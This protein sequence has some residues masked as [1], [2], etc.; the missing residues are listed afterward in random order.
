M[1]GV[2]LADMVAAH[3]EPWH[4]QA[5]CVGQPQEW[6]F[7]SDDDETG[8]DGNHAL[9][10]KGVCAECPV[11]VDCAFY[12]VTRGEMHGIW[13]GLGGSK[14]KF[15]RR[16]WADYGNPIVLRNQLA[17]EILVMQGGLRP[18]MPKSKCLRCGTLIPA[19]RHPIDRNTPGTKCNSPVAYAKGARCWQARMGNAMRP[20]GPGLARTA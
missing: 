9:E 3:R 19:G 2:N 20:A 14:L 15:F 4:Q 16:L 1:E 8:D 18:M 12:A 17:S 13:G 10:A 11:A 7:P 5:A 6:F